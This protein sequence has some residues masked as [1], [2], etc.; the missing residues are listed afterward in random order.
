MYI[1]HRNNKFHIREGIPLSEKSIPLIEL[2]TVETEYLGVPYTKC[3]GQKI[4]GERY[5]D[6]DITVCRIVRKVENIIKNLFTNNIE[7]EHFLRIL[8]KLCQ[9]F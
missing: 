1:S 6:Y 8:Q 2:R 9:K 4:H 3:T 5:G 7:F